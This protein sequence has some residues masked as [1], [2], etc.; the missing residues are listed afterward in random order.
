MEVHKGVVLVVSGPSGT[1]K[2]TILAGFKKE[3][4]DVV[5]SVSVTTRQPR[6]SEVES[7][8]YF[9]KT[10]EQ[11][12]QMIQEGQLLEWVNYCDNYYGTP[13]AFIMDNIKK[14]YD[15]VVEVEVEGAL[16]IKENYPESVLVFIMPP[17]FEDLY[18][19]I[20]K[21]GS[22]TEITRSKRL[23]TAL[24]EVEL[25][26]RYDYMIVNKNV[27]L[28]VDQLH[29]ILMTQKHKTIRYEEFIEKIL[30]EGFTYER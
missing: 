10:K 3:H 21:R 19:R 12:H 17:T 24:Y 16:K 8:N 11:F 29:C 25:S 27:Q 15:I 13:K 30:K 5:F 18:H 7:V 23:Q 6:H 20:N 2:G 26:K 1:G 22:E 9:F 4:K 14:G 28:A